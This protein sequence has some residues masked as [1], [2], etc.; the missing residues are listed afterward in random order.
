ML[1]GREKVEFTKKCSLREDEFY[2]SNPTDDE[3]AT[4]CRKTEGEG[5]KV[6]AMKAVM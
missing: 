6:C 2:I 4:Y 5:M 3:Y 1:L